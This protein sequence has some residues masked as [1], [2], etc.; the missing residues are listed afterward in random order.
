MARSTY[1]TEATDQARKRDRPLS[2][3]VEQQ[4]NENLKRLYQQ[5]AAEP[6]PDR[7]VQL[8]DSLKKQ[9]SSK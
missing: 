5:T 1:R 9:D 7:L 4:I 6:L 8:L 2:P 3:S